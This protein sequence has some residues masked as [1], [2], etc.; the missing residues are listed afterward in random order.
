MPDRMPPIKP[1]KHTTKLITEDHLRATKHHL[2]ET[3]T[4]YRCQACHSWISK[5][6]KFLCDFLDSPCLPTT[7]NRLISVV[8]GKQHTHPTHSLALYGGMYICLA[9]GYTGRERINTT[10][11]GSPCKSCPTYACKQNIRKYIQGKPLPNPGWPFRTDPAN[12]TQIKFS[13]KHAFTN[14]LDQE[15]AN[16]IVKLVKQLD[17]IERQQKLQDAKQIEFENQLSPCIDTSY[18][19]SVQLFPPLTN[20]TLPSSSSG[21]TVNSLDNAEIDIEE[22]DLEFE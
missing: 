11:L 7:T 13:H 22:S 6:A 2:T 20:L 21:T 4:K 17:N 10:G 16:A 9:C 8:I 14:N 12:S 19:Q 5:N 18:K 1:P 15:E 3:S